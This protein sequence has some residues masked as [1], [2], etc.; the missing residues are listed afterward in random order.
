MAS[1][2]NRKWGRKKKQPAQIRYVQEGRSQ[3]NK[4]R[5]ILKDALRSKKD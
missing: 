5:R 4:E 3:K 1:K 2:T